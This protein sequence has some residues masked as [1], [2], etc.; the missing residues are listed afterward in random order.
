MLARTFSKARPRHTH[1]HTH[2]HHAPAL[3]AMCACGRASGAAGRRPLVTPIAHRSCV[4]G[5]SYGHAFK[6]EWACCQGGA[7]YIRGQLTRIAHY[8]EGVRAVQRTQLTPCVCPH[9][10]GL[11]K[12]CCV[13]GVKSVEW[14]SLSV[15]ADIVGCTHV[16]V[17]PHVLHTCMHNTRA[18][19]HAHPCAHRHAHA[20]SPH[21]PCPHSGVRPRAV[22]QAPG[23]RT[24][25]QR[26]CRLCG[27]ACGAAAAAALEDGP[28][29]AVRAC[30][31]G[32]IRSQPTIAD[33]TPVHA[34]R[35]FTFPVKS[36][37]CACTRSYGGSSL[38]QHSTT[39]QA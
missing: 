8:L 22:R 12:G 32:H 17:N 4:L 26:A 3:R 38:Q 11:C 18:Y 30:F 16:G 7:I 6:V 36:V 33:D 39:S 10:Q 23:E 27:G 29:H 19:E 21:P 25:R 20:L 35:A 5:P 31:S 1:T 34:V 24:S 28:V 9:R 2:V 13:N 37:L 14:H 15:A